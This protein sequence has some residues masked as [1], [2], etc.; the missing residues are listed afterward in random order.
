MWDMAAKIKT[1]Y[2]CSVCGHQSPKWNGKCLNCG[3]WDSY[4]EKRMQ[5]KQKKNSLQG[6]LKDMNTD[7]KPIAVRDIPAQPQVRMDTKNTELN[8]VLGGGV[9]PG[10]VVLIGGQPGIGKSTLLLQTAL[11]M[12]VRILYVS[13]EES[14]H[15]I[16]MR[17]DR[18]SGQNELCLVYNET[19]I[20]LILQEAEKIQ[21]ALMVLDSIQTCRTSDLDSLPGSVA[22]IRACAQLVQE[23]AK[24]SNVSVFL[25]GHINKEGNIAGPM[26]LEHIVDTV[27]LFEGDR[28]FQFRLLRAAKNR[29]G[30]T[31]EI[32]IF[33]MRSDGLQPIDNPSELFLSNRFTEV[34]GQ[35][36]GT[37]QEGRRTVL[38]EVQV[39][40]NKAIFGTPQR[41]ATGFDMKRLHMVLAV[42]ENKLGLFFGQKDVYLNIAGGLKIQETAMDMAVVA[43]VLSAH[44]DLSIPGNYCF[45]GELSLSGQFS[46]VTQMDQRINE[47]R[48]MGFDQIFIPA[49][50]P[51]SKKTEDGQLIS[52]RHVESLYHLMKDHL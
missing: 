30:N 31:D 25:I 26:L 17:A 41:S 52:V 47:A 18:I 10:S 40:I 29:F 2:E 43:A 23:Y 19:D 20:H 51:S 42:I 38:S 48:R 9:V 33:D 12:P 22:Q 5:P 39:L 44:F 34:S 4:E 11:N 7:S 6:V 14:N 27:L 36:I 16:K 45:I 21:P 28:K 37:L 50:S 15:Q 24:K 1:Y 13:G 3:S 46:G 8:R 32:G 35:A 49:A